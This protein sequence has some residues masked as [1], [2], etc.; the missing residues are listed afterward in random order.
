MPHFSVRRV[1]EH[2]YVSHPAYIREKAIELRTERGMTID[3]IAGRL[4]LGR[5]TIYYWVREIPIKR[6]SNRQSAAQKLA[7]AAMQKKFADKRRAAYEVGLA[8]FDKLA[9]DPLF[10]D[11][12]CTYIAEGY[13]RSRN[14]V[15]VAN[16]DPVMISML[17]RFV[18]RYA[19]NLVTYSIQYHAD[20]DLDHLRAF[21]ASRLGIDPDAIRLQRKSNSNQLNGRTWR[22]KHG[23]LTIW[24]NDT[25]FRSRLQ[26][27]IDRLRSDWSA[28]YT[29]PT[30]G[31]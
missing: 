14:Q 9:T 16:S 2:V 17:D 27:W 31:V 15:S 26:G 28:G 7:T 30:H 25:Q 21:W 24:A 8:E 19:R 4:A 5:S 11:F 22:S 10:R 6:D 23:V 13:K 3:E 18:R 12:V 1:S 29:S 20:Q